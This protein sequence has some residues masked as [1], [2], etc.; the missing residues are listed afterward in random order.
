MLALTLS[1]SAPMVAGRGMPRPYK[2]CDVGAGRPRGHPAARSTTVFLLRRVTAM[3]DPRTRHAVGRHHKRLH[4]GWNTRRDHK[5]NLRGATSN[6][7][8]PQIE[9]PR[10]F[11]DRDRNMKARFGAV[12]PPSFPPRGCAGKEGRVHI[13]LPG[14]E[15]YHY[16]AR[17]SGG[18][19]APDARTVKEC[20]VRS[21]WC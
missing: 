6:V 13:A 7:G 12:C 16:V 2:G 9:S 19:R 5:I 14:H 15:Q 21:G 4:P 8:I 17:F 20:P 3:A 18:L 11:P 10:L 1:A